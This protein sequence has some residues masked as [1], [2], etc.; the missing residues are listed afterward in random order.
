VLGLR[1]AQRLHLPL[2]KRESV[3]GVGVSATARHLTGV[4]ATAS[5][6]LLSN[7]SLAVD[8][9]SAEELCSKPVDGLIG[10]GFFKD[11]VVQIDY[12]RHVLRIASSAAAATAAQRL[13]AK[14]MNGI[15]CVPVSVNESN[16]RWTRLDTG[17]NDALH[18]VI[19]RPANRSDHGAVSIGFVTD[20]DDTSLTSVS[21]G[22]RTLHPVK[23]ALHSSQLFPGEAGLLGNGL[24]SQ[25][26]VTV[27]WPNRQ[28]LLVDAPR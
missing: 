12:V 7:V 19:P 26:V 2:G 3:H 18:W 1:T 28:V 15:L 17:C 11:R 6:V 22:K 8:L 14:M 21:L 16:V 23:T 10:I 27:D 25:F 5:G 24:L 20:T 9:S 13:P 4:D